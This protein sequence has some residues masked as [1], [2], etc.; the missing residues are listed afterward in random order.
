M[1]IDSLKTEMYE[2]SPEVAKAINQIVQFFVSEG[3][4]KPH[5][6]MSLAISVCAQVF[7]ANGGN[8]DQGET[9]G[10]MVKKGIITTLDAYKSAMRVNSPGGRA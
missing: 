2:A 5:V 1:V 4:G 7:L 6:S 9:I 8:I 10:D 3:K